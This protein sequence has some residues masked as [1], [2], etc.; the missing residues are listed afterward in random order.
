MV[1]VC[2]E[3][4]EAESHESSETEENVSHWRKC[5]NKTKFAQFKF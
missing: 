1:C 4:G 5:H 3:Y 2:A